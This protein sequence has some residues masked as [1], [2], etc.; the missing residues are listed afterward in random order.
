MKEKPRKS[1]KNGQMKNNLR[2]SGASGF[3]L[4]GICANPG[5]CS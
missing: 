1:G 2:D 4:Y 3:P 5:V